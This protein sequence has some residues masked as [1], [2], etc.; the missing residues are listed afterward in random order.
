[1][2]GPGAAFPGPGGVLA[3]PQAVPAEVA[4]PPSSLS[5]T[6]SLQWWQRPEYAGL[7]NLFAGGGMGTGGFG[8]FE[9]FGGGFSGGSGVG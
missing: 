5:P 2:S 1:V 9:G 7:G 3:P 8:G 4:R 6:S